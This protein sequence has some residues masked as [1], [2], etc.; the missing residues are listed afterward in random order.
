M[1]VDRDAFLS[2]RKESENG[3]PQLFL[4]AYAWWQHNTSQSASLIYLFLYL[5]H[6]FLSSLFCVLISG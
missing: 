1:C 3:G 2:I 4:H 5:T 6:L